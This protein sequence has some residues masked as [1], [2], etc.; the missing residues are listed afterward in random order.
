MNIWKILSLV[1]GTKQDRD[2][3]KLRPILAAVN[4]KWESVKKLSD[5]ELRNKTREFRER[6][7]KEETLDDI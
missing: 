5:D 6:L 7:A 3:K 1:F 4:E 2:M